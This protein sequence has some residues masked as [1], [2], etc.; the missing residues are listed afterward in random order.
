MQVE[1]DRQAKRDQEQAEHAAKSA[2]LD[3]QIRLA[4]E[5][6]TDEQAAEERTQALEQKTRDLDMARRLAQESPNVAL[7]AKPEA[8]TAHSVSSTSGPATV[9]R[10]HTSRGQERNP[11][12]NQHETEDMNSAPE[13]EWDR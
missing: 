6:I 10:P 2:E 4:R 13:R 8:A 3:Q 7:G 1:L 11:G 5:T 12:I 9:A